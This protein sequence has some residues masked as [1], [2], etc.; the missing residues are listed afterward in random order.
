MAALVGADGN[1]EPAVARIER[2][3]RDWRVLV[4]IDNLESVLADPDP[5][6]LPLLGRIAKVGESRMLLTSRESPPEVVGAAEQRLRPLGE[7]EG[8]VLVAGV[9]RAAGLD[10]PRGEDGAWVGQLVERVGGHA[11]SLVLLAPRV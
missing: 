6:L 5:E 9:L 2:A 1:L 10:V 8:R 3:L 11:R 7:E 4:V